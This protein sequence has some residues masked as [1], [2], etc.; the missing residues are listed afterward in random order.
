[1]VNVWKHT[2]HG[3]YGLLASDCFFLISGLFLCENAFKKKAK[4]P[5]EVFLLSLNLA[6][7]KRSTSGSEIHM[8]ECNIVQAGRGS[9]M[10][11]GLSE[12]NPCGNPCNHWCVM[13]L[14]YGWA[15]WDMKGISGDTDLK[16][17]H[18]MHCFCHM[19]LFL[20]YSIFGGMLC[21]KRTG[22]WILLKYLNTKVQLFIW[23]S[24]V[25][26]ISPSW[27]W[28]LFP[29]ETMEQPSS[30]WTQKNI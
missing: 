17:N 6:S 10:E 1:M 18:G 3:C 11:R 2:I 13:E 19:G 4:H 8:T 27:I 24:V 7:Q 16:I 21:L 25:L 9:G 28:F 20:E 5:F 23:G 12:R 14:P 30:V 26:L 29:H 15:F 22:G